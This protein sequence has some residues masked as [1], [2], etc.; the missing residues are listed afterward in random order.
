MTMLRQLAEQK[1]REHL[2]ELDDD[3]NPM[4]VKNHEVRHLA[5]ALLDFGR[6][7]AERALK[8]YI[9]E[10]VAFY[11]LVPEAIRAAEESDS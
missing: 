4:P 3:G 1:A 6:L 7:F 8:Q 2:A 10:Q 11:A 5:A 9:G